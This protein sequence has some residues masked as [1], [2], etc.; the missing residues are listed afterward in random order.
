MLTDSF[1]P[2]PPPSVP[3]FDKEKEETLVYEGLPP[4]KPKRAEAEIVVF[5]NVATV[6]MVE[7]GEVRE[8]W[9]RGWDASSSSQEHHGL[10][11]AVIQ[12]G[13]MVCFGRRTSCHSSLP[14]D[15]DKGEAKGEVQVHHI[16]LKGGSIAPG[17]LTHGAPGAASYGST[18]G[19]EEIALEPSTGDG[20][21]LDP[22]AGGA[23][24]GAIGGR[25]AGVP[26]V[27]AVDGL[28]FNGRD[29]L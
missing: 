12:N 21:V 19:L 3:N 8:V 27:R 1:T 14:S 16:D 23:K 20:K 2:P 5:E 9:N 4:L 6:Y 26:V 22:L 7:S 28:Q 17:L 29:M 24:L 13:S 11:I 10:G 15:A 18:L 25:G